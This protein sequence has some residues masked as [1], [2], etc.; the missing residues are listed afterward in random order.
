MKITEREGFPSFPR[1]NSTKRT[2]G[3]SHE[4]PVCCYLSG[5]ERGAVVL[6]GHSNGTAD[7]G[8]LLNEILDVE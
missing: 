4:T 1:L 5:S 8:E 3:S 6:L 2:E 7:T